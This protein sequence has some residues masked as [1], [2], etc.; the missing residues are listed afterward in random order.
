MGLILSYL[1]VCLLTL[2]LSRVVPGVGSPFSLLTNDLRVL[3]TCIV[4]P[5]GRIAPIRKDYEQSAKTIA[6]GG[7][8]VGE[9]FWQWSEEQVKPYL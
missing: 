4:I 7:T 6:E 8:G 5:W 2:Q 3:K 1:R 9:R